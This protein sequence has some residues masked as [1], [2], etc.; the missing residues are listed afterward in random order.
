MAS[1]PGP[2]MAGASHSIAEGFRVPARLLDPAV[3]AAAEAVGGWVGAP[4][5]IVL[6]GSH[7][8]GDAVERVLDGSRL[9]L[10]DVDLHVV[11]ADAAARRTAE[12]GV[13]AA[14]PA[15]DRRRR[16]QGERGPLEIAI[17]TVAEWAALPARP[18]TLD[19]RASGVVIHGDAAW[20]DRLP[21]WTA[22]DVPREEVLLLLENRAFELIR[23]AR[24]PAGDRVDALLAA[25][26]QYKTALDLA[27]VERLVDRAWEA[28]PAERVRVARRARA[29]RAVIAPD[30]AW[31]RALAWRN[32]S[33]PA[34]AERETDR[35][36]IADAWVAC[37]SALVAPGAGFETVAG[38]AARRARLRR[39]V[40]LALRP[41]IPPSCAPSLASRLRHALAGTPQH[42]LNASAGAF[43]AA[44]VLARREPARAAAIEARLTSL[45]TQLGAVRP[46]THADTADRLLATWERWTN[47]ATRGEALR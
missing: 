37:W 15:F 21:R 42:R 18:G 4:L 11:V 32:G 33:T 40:R 39:R 45:L 27:T 46:G 22:A 13:A 6:G 9:V 14:R 17:H 41:E 19:L 16:E 10:S 36:A 44:E 34:E 35:R 23:S 3:L 8:R 12:L 38:R 30:P 1:E 47:G 43:L 29:A 24:A 5:A 28:D 26:A 2:R 25:H 20:R 31:D 7:A